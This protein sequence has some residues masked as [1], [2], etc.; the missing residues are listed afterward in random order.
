VSVAFVCTTAMGA[1]LAAWTVLTVL[2]QF[3]RGSLIRR[4]KR[5]DVFALIPTWTF[6]APR[7]GITDYNVLYRDSDPVGALSPW[8]EL[9]PYRTCASRVVWSPDKRARKSLGDMCQSLVRLASARSGA[10]PR[11]EVTYLALLGAV[12]RRPRSGMAARRQFIIVRSFGYLRVRPPE[13][14]FASDFHT[15]DDDR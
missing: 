6:F 13:V 5:H 7:P 2:N 15:L 9:W 3:N 14:L 8:R 11:L 1:V 10:K 12:S 4:V